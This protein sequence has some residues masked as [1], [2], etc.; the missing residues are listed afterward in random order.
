MKNT[1]FSDARFWSWILYGWVQS[2]IVC[3]IAFGVPSSLDMI[4]PDC[5]GGSQFSPA[6][7]GKLY[8]LWPAGQ[9]V[10]FSCVCLANL[11]ILA[12]QSNFTGWG[13][14]L[15]L[16]Q[17]LSYFAVLKIENESPKFSQVYQFWEEAMT[18]PAAWLSFFFIITWSYHIDR[19]ANETHRFCATPKDKLNQI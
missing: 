15:M 5:T 8:S 13:E 9:N 12:Q 3:L 18:N 14:I 16:L 11:R 4:K 1:K 17:I 19:F 6:E 2:L 7:N 10:F